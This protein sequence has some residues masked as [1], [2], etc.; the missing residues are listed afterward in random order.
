M[1]VLLCMCYYVCVIMYVLLPVRMC[2]YVCVIK[3]K[4]MVVL[5]GI[6]HYFL[7]QFLLICMYVL[8]CMCY[9][10]C[11]IMYVLLCMCYYRYVCVIMYV[12][13]C[14][15]YYVCVIDQR[16]T[17]NLLV[18]SPLSYLPS[19]PVL[20][21]WQLFIMLCDVDNNNKII[22][23]TLTA[24]LPTF[25][26][27]FLVVLG[28]KGR[29]ISCNI[30]PAERAIWRN[31]DR[32]R[33]CCMTPVTYRVIILV[34]CIHT[35]ITASE[36]CA[37]HQ[38]FAQIIRGLRKSSEVCAN[39]QRFAQIIRGLRK[40]SEVC[41]DHQGFAQIIRGLRRSSEVCANHQRFAQIIR[42]LRKSSEVCARY[43]QTSDVAQTQ[44]CAATEV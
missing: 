35:A 13:L 8:L 20:G 44:F 6:K 1:Y 7:K 10:V 3:V 4:R 38:R 32:S 33:M 11:V 27:F 15:C 41:A 36:V 29:S 26:S 5:N 17:T 43:A 14:M 16:S 9:Y 23:S 40:S 42:G 37:N 18:H 39:H 24:R 12:L 21:H 19:S 30:G 22:I 2:Y 31:M 28:V 25:F 34:Y